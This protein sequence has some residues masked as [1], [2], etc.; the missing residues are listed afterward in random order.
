MSH[1]NQ[2]SES[3]AHTFKTLSSH[4][5]ESRFKFWRYTDTSHGINKKD[6]DMKLHMVQLTVWDNYIS[7]CYRATG[8]VLQTCSRNPS[9]WGRSSIMHCP[10]QWS[11]KR[12]PELTYHN[13]KSTV[14]G[15]GKCSVPDT[16][17]VHTTDVRCHLLCHWNGLWS[18][19]CRGLER[20]V[21][22]L[23]CQVVLQIQQ[24]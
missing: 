6:K 17:S 20:E 7:H 4:P 16:R 15:K 10:V 18:C 8:I 23:P 21:P 11:S 19:C 9:I 1:L 5:Q 22:L 24:I 14:E 13:K 12:W 2:W 3:T